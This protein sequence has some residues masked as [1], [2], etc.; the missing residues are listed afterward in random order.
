MKYL[1]CLML[2]VAMGCKSQ[3]TTPTT[4]VETPPVV[5]LPPIEVIV[6]PAPV[7]VEPA[8]PVSTYTEADVMKIVK[9]SSCS[10]YTWGNRGRASEGYLKAVAMTYAGQVCSPS[11]SASN[12][13]KGDKNL[14]VATHYP[15]EANLETVYALLIG[16]GMRESSGRQC[17]GVD[18]SAS[19]Y[20]ANTAEAGLFQT[21]YNA[22]LHPY[23]KVS[24]K[25]ELEALM[26]SYL[27]DNKSCYS[28]NTCTTKNYGTG[29]GMEFQKLA[30]QCPAF[31]VRTHATMMRVL[32][33]HYGPLINKAAELRPECVDMLTKI[34]AAVKP[35]C[36]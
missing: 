21:S 35:T 6:E 19:N 1:L 28:W 17:T 15:I 12:A 13:V 26:D 18:E 3:P 10:T 30:K 8:K 36:K 34:K 25:A 20:A 22:F 5:V 27:A 33:R 31:S 16:S 11:P 14:D 23:I 32:Y 24:D 29:R 2:V 9:A 4:P 7:V